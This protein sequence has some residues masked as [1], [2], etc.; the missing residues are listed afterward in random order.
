[1][2]IDVDVDDLVAAHLVSLGRPRCLL[3]TRQILRLA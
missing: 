1:V 3:A 2:R